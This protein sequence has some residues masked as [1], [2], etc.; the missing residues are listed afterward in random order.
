MEKENKLPEFRKN[1]SFYIREG[2]ISKAIICIA[3]NPGINIFR[4]N[5][6]IK[7]LG[8]GSNRVKGL[9]Y[10]LL[11]ADIIDAKNQLTDFG[12]ILLDNDR[13][14]ENTS[15]WFLIHRKLVKNKQKCPVFNWVFSSDFNSFRESEIEDSIISFYKVVSNVEKC[16]N[17]VDAIVIFRV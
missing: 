5:D 11:A 3:E 14:L 1:E 9:H 17:F 12:N 4:K 7:F 6:G 13:Y 16:N 2:W 10:W 15:S 8:I